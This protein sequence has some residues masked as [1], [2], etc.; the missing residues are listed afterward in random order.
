MQYVNYMRRKMHNMNLFGEA[1]GYPC[2]FTGN[3]SPLEDY[4]IYGASGGVGDPTANLL[5]YTKFVTRNVWAGITWEALGD[6]SIRAT[7]TQTAALCAF[8]LFSAADLTDFQNSLIDGQTYYLN[9]FRSVNPP[10]GER[11]YLFM[12]IRRAATGTVQYF[13]GDTGTTFVWYEGDTITALELRIYSTDGTLRTVD[14]T[15]KPLVAESAVAVDYEPYGYKIPIFNN[16][17]PSAVVY[18][19]SPL[20]EYEYTDYKNQCINRG[21]TITDCN[22]PQI[23]TV[24]GQNSLSAELNVSSYPQ[25]I[26][27]K[28]KK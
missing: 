10:T 14:V 20:C 11:F 21:G 7:G 28:Y 16:G 5:D 3:G 25:K 1:E 8:A 12:G 9:G 26:Y 18:I 22:I 27:V 19:N 6:G 23:I 24:A 2:T 13:S 4:R 17:N 15:F